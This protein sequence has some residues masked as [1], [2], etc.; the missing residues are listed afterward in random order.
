[1]D[2][3]SANT[4]ICDSHDGVIFDEPTLIAYNKRSGRIIGIGNQARD[5]VGRVSGYVVVERPIR[6]GRVSSIELLDH[7]F[8]AL[9]KA[10]S[11][12]R[13]SRPKAIV[14]VPASA[15]LVESRS[16]IT[17]LKNAGFSEVVTLDTVLASAIGIGFDVNEPN[18]SMVVNLGAATALSGIIAFGGV[19]AESHAFCGGN[20]MDQAIMD[21]LKYRS[22]VS[23]DESV[24]EEIKLALAR[25][26]DE[27]A[28]YM[29]SLIG[30]DLTSGSPIKVEIDEGDVR[31]V[32]ADP[33][34]RVIEVMLDN[35]SH[36]PAELAQDL[37]FG[38][39]HLCGGHSQLPG[40]AEAIANS[41]NIPVTVVDEPRYCTA[42][43]L[44]RYIT[45][46]HRWS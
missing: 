19:V 8:Q 15:T 42:N 31:D 4:V 45:E 33:V 20:A 34:K 26:S 36:C 9:M 38:G 14:A 5:V 29:S 12:R 44:A 16:I 23:V 1:M 2:L 37:V 46:T 27:P 41:V 35:L 7:Y 32:I 13:F 18:G 39:V 22:H 17:A 30:R 28:R 11:V 43:G 10:L 21:L 24:A 40:L 3:G 25:V 6:D